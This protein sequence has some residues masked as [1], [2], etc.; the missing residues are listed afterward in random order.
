MSP[1]EP[2]ILWKE[3]V[4][5]FLLNEFETAVLSKEKKHTYFTSACFFRLLL[6]LMKI[7]KYVNKCVEKRN[8]Q[9]TQQIFWEKK[10]FFFF[11]FG[12]GLQLRIYTNCTYNIFKTEMPLDFIHYFSNRKLNIFI[13]IITLFLNFFV[14]RA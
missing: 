7:L 8:Y 10:F 1:V 9:L 5:I 11:F 4:E 2:F 14:H 12:G 3:Q 6:R 13:K